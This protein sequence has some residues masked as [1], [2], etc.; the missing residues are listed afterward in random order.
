M[1]ANIRLPE[2]EPMDARA[3]WQVATAADQ[4]AISSLASRARASLTLRHYD[5]D[6]EWQSL[7]ADARDEMIALVDAG[8]DGLQGFVS[9]HAHDAS[10]EHRLAGIAIFRKRMRRFDIYEA[11]VTRRLDK[12]EAI[13]SGLVALGERMPRGGAIFLEAVPAGSELHAILASPQDRLRQSFYVLP[14][15][16]TTVGSIKWSGSVEEYLKTLGKGS[17]RDLKRTTSALMSDTAVRCAVKRFVAPT[18]V[19]RF[20]QDGILISDKTYQKK[21]L[22]RGLALGGKVEAQIRFA[23]AKGAFIGH[24]LYVN[25]A[26]VAFQYGISYRRT[27]FVE[28]VGYD[29]AWANRHVGSVLFFEVLSDFE[30]NKDDIGAL[31]FGQGMTLFKERTTNAQQPVAHY[32]LLKRTAS[33]FVVYQAART[34]KGFAQLLHRVLDRLRIRESIKAVARRW[35]GHGRMR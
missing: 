28:Q 20:F 16:D 22:G 31:D 15:G 24:I 21:L 25:D 27:H 6:I 14:W 11:V 12:R 4:A 32:V 18:D 5:Q 9:V 10:I 13:A 34:A 3:A 7:G 1:N 2:A 30:K 17:R 33:G 26:P 19:D 8:P 29:P 23:A 35:T